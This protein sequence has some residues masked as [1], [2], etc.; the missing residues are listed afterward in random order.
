MTENGGNAEWGSIGAEAQG[1][2]MKYL[3]QFSALFNNMAQ[4][5]LARGLQGDS[6]GPS[7]SPMFDAQK[8]QE[9]LSSGVEVDTAKLLTQQMAFMERQTELWQNASKAMMG[10]KVEPIVSEPKG[11]KRFKDSDWSDNPVFS[12]LKQAYLL[13]AEMMQ[14]TVD[15][16][17]FPDEKT[18]E[19]VKFYTRQYLSSVAPGNYVLTN[20]EVCREILATK[21]ENLAR[22]AE[23][24]L[25]DLERS[26]LEAFR[27]TQSDDSAFEVGGNLAT[28]PGKVVFQNELIQLI[29][30]APSTEQVYKR[31]ILF[32]PPFINKYYIL[33]LD[34]RK[35]L[36][37]WLLDQGHAVF[38]IS[39]VN[40]DASLAHI[41][42]GDYM[43]LGPLAAL[44]VVQA[45]TGAD[46]VNMVGFCIGGTLLAMAA[47][48]LKVRGDKR[49]NSLTFLTTLLDFSEPGE[50]GNYLS[51]QLLP[52][53]EQSVEEKGVF[54]GRILGL[55]FS[56]LRENSLFWSYFI[57][58]Y[59]KGKDPVAF[60]ILYWNND[61]T[62]L[63][64]AAFQQYVE[65]TYC[66]N[67]LKEPGGVTVDDV[68]IDLSTIDCPSYFLA[69]ANDHIVLW[70]GAYQGAKLLSGP[71]RFVLAGSGHL[72]GVINPAE[73]GK[74]PH[75]LNGDWPQEADAWLADAEQQ[76]G[77]WW[78]DWDQWLGSISGDKVKA[79]KPGRSKKY[80]ALEDAPGSYV[81]VRL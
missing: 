69:T 51:D 4:E 31:P 17:K 27:I 25:R 45:I 62:N 36:M 60:D 12:Y 66:D 41:D 80:P 29:H 42:F 79:K 70:Q 49:I 35:S 54:D 38:M 28:T 65:S 50:L 20:P 76:D 72:A 53:I 43:K 57:N 3:E 5:A 15:A 77:S 68:A 24:F 48:Y 55:S 33:D 18:S 8:F 34:E 46:K 21:G 22:G 14:S 30:Y 23:N 2:V 1:E 11:D 47:A 52:L 9:L 44:D 58:N 26:P 61:S 19:Q 37:R 81:K 32:T 64:A 16:M 75:W 71:T 67:Q 40:P 56:L 74:Y 6:S 73:E 63:P 13:N 59:L 10:E 7:P 78:P 39:W